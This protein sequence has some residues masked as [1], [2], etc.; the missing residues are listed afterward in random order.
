MK[1]I[2]AQ[3]QLATNLS[4]ISRAVP[5]RPTHPVLANVLL[6]ADEE[7]QQVS[8]TAFDLSLGIK[9][10]F[11]AKVETSG[12]LTL[13][14]KLFNDIISRLP[15]GEV[16]L[17][18]ERPSTGED[19]AAEAGILA[20]ITSSSGRYE[21]RGMS[22]E[23]F[24]ALPTISEG[25][26]VQL[27]AEALMQGLHGTLFATSGDET[28][29]VLTGVHLIVHADSLEFAATD[30]HRLAIVETINEKEDSDDEVE[31][32]EDAEELEVTVPARALRELDRIV[33]MHEGHEPISLNFDPGQI[34]LELGGFRLTSRTLEGQY[35]A[36]SQL[37]PRSFERQVTVERRQLLSALE[38]IGVLADRK[39][40]IVK[41]SIDQEKQMLSLSVEAADVGSGRE[42]MSAQIT[43]ESLDIAFNVK[44]AMESL[45][46]ISATEIIIKL[47]S[48]TSPVVLSPLTGVKMTHLIMPVQMRG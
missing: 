32:D 38:R 34:V 29:Q 1:F 27:P 20:T 33:G 47:N 35:P 45:K 2:C 11:A 3:N 44:Y 24:P 22:A 39:N 19:S 36:Y 30:G 37:V 18:D 31:P 8:L 28:K 5:S 42:S 21:V 4:L 7:Q 6:S 43:G 46:N 26:T 40:N 14:A 41:F 16:T 17:D 12:T 10:S 9:T 25:Q 23:E 15:D 48:A 13:P